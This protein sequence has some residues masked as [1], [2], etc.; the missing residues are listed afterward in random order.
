MVDGYTAALPLGSGSIGQGGPN[1]RQHDLRRPAAS[2][3]EVEST[4]RGRFR[5]RRRTSSRGSAELASCRSRGEG[6]FS[7]AIAYYMRGGE[8]KKT[9][10]CHRVAGKILLPLH[11]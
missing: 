6:E 10:K 11:G 8:A 9:R 7:P 1:K 5:G 4:D 3:P 2:S